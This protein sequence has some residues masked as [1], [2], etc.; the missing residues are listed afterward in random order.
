MGN[1]QI[2]ELLNKNK[3][4]YLF[5]HI[6]IQTET[7]QG[8]ICTEFKFTRLYFQKK[9]VQQKILN[10]KVNLEGKVHNN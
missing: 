4:E 1:F 2:K 7:K 10:S 9:N 6:N 5:K 8:S 3:P